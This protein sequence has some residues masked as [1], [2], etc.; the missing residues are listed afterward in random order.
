M[1][2]RVMRL[3]LLILLQSTCQEALTAAAFVGSLD[4]GFAQFPRIE[5]PPSLSKC[6]EKMF[7]LAPSER[8]VLQYTK[9]RYPW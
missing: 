2:N 1:A 6:D 8:T 5:K 4:Q 3:S 7:A 9:F